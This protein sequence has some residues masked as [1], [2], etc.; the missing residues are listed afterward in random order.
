MH[1][2]MVQFADPIWLLAIPA[3]L[4]AG[5]LLLRHRPT[6]PYPSTRLVGQL[7]RSVWARLYW[8]PELLRMAAVVLVLLALARPQRQ[9]GAYRIRKPGVALQ[10]LVDCSGSMRVP[11]FELAGRKVSRLEALK[12]V[13]RRFVAGGDGLPGRPDDLIGLITFA[14]LPDTKC[15][16]TVS[17]E[18]LL[19]HI[20]ALAP[21]RPAD[22]GT[23]IGDAIAWAVNELGQTEA[24]SK[25]I[26]LLSDGVNEPV[27]LQRE[28]E[29]LDPVHAAA[30]AGAL[31]VRIH[32]IGVGGAG[33]VFAV[34][35][36]GGRTIEYVRA[37]PINE[38][39][40]RA[41]AS[42]TGGEYFHASDTRSLAAICRKLDQLE[43]TPATALLYRQYDELFVPLVLAALGL[44]CLEQ[45]LAA[46]WLRRVP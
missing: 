31:G 3:A 39:L 23:N 19:A 9:A 2:A 17:H 1:E 13:F 30:A 40:L 34:S 32:T 24:K 35:A 6:L 16:L 43:R 37:E 41:I 21:A 14:N 5:W 7:P 26:V 38:R 36:K 11:D 20:D 45:F 18:V 8:L 12:H 4:L 28:H 22:D 42:A 29:P 33:G 44:L 46:T 27:R 25:A 10:L 15:P